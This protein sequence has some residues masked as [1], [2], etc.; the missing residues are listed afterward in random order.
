MAGDTVS[1]IPKYA[2]NGA[3]V[4]SLG[5]VRRPAA[6]FVSVWYGTPVSA[7]ITFSVLSLALIA[8]LSSCSRFVFM[9]TLYSRFRRSASATFGC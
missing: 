6:T 8:A 9:R 7:A 3:M 5:F 2:S 1:A 4:L